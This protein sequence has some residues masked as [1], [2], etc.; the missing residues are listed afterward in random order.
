MLTEGRGA[1]PVGGVQAADRSDRR[2]ATWRR[3]QRDLGR[4]N[5]RVGRDFVTG[6]TRRRARGDADASQVRQVR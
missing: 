2:S 5:A 3:R 6:V 1:G 4:D